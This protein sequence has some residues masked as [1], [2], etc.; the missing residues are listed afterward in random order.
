MTVSEI[1]SWPFSQVRLVGFE[2]VDDLRDLARRMLAPVGSGTWAS[3]MS[4]IDWKRP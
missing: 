2:R 4:S 3:R 1:A